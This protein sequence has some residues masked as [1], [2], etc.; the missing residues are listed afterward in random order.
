[1]VDKF[2]YIKMRTFW[3]RQILK[4]DFQRNIN[5]SYKSSPVVNLSSSCV[6]IKL[7]NVNSFII[8]HCTLRSPF[9]NVCTIVFFFFKLLHYCIRLAQSMFVR[10]PRSINSVLLIQAK[11]L[12]LLLKK[13]IMYYPSFHNTSYSRSAESFQC[14]YAMPSFVRLFNVHFSMRHSVRIEVTIQ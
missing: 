12:L 7:A 11:Q 9:I 5:C 13:N 4:N 2:K 3:D 8:W 6:V 10:L 1:M 14:S